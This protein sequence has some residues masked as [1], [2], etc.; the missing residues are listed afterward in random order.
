[1]PASEGKL[2][3]LKLKFAVQAVLG[4]SL[5]SVAPAFAATAAPA[6][7]A[8]VSNQA[9]AKAVQDLLQSMQFEK[10]LRGVAARSRYQSEAQRQA[11]FAKLEKTPPAEVYRRM[12]P[13][14][15]PVV[16]AATATEMT[17]FYNTPY[18]KQVIHKK[19]NSGAQLNMGGA[20]AAIPQDEKKERKRAAYV[21]ASKELAD[22][23][24]M[25]EHEAFKLLQQINKEKR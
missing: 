15:L 5:V 2:M 9:H 14:L 19:Y 10:V 6:A 12:A 17:R 20:K 7:P 18:G 25:L 24:P 23:E 3:K 21:Q 13:S 1:M 22:A 11:V 8:A 16:S 4:L